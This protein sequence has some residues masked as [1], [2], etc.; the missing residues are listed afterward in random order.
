[1]KG[2]IHPQSEILIRLLPNDGLTRRLC[3]LLV[4]APRS[5]KDRAEFVLLATSATR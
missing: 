1:M 5:A 4:I 3:F 2:S